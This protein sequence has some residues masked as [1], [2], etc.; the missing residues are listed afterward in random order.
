MRGNRWLSLALFALVH[1]AAAAEA[2]TNPCAARATS[3]VV[4]VNDDRLWLCQEGRL[5]KEYLVATGR[6][7]SGKSQEGDD[8]TPLGTY[9]LGA[10]RLSHDFGIFVPIG[11]PTI[12]QRKRGNTGG[13]VGLH[14]PPRGFVWAG[15]LNTWIDWTAGCIAVPTNTAISEIAD[16]IRRQNPSAIHIE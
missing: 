9:P 5:V 12:E 16:W 7:G 14:G 13:A 1:S 10:P 15:R 8:K 11:Y 4:H 6:G 3:I 2:P